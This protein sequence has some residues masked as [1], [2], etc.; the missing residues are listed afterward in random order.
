VVELVETRPWSLVPVVEPVE[1]PDK[2]NHRSGDFSSP[3]R[4][5]T[6][7]PPFPTRDTSREAARGILTA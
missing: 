2:L 6:V 4:N 5:R 1:T 3:A 7:T